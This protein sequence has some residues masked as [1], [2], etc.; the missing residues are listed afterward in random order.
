MRCPE[1]D[2]ENTDDSKF[3]MTC[4]TSL[5]DVVA[6][7]VAEPAV[8][9]GT[10]AVAESG[11]S[12][13]A[14]VSSPAPSD[15]VPEANPWLPSEATGDPAV[16]EPA[17]P[18]PAPPVDEAPA[19]PAPP[20]DEAPAPPAPLG[21]PLP[22]P[23][24]D[25][26]GALPPPPG[27]QAWTPPPP[28]SGLPTSLVPPAG[29]TPPWQADPPPPG[30]LDPIEIPVPPAAPP[31]PITMVVGPADPHGLAGQL[32]RIGDQTRAHAEGPLHLAASLLRLPEEVDVV[33]PGL[34]DGVV[35]ILVVTNE[36]ALLVNTRRWTPVV[37]DLP[38]APGLKVDGWQDEHTAVLTLTGDQ[39]ARIE[40]IVDKPL[41]FEAAR[42]IR[43]RVAAAPAAR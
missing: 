11:H 15:V 41:A 31:A 38:I 32:A 13:P 2:T 40:A 5:R 10:A 3:C 21:A 1:C 27:A 30:S 20:V 43:E 17:E 9:G 8:D 16:V 34:I 26:S 14:E 6:A 18:A 36:R 42:I 33:V 24:P 12:E 39:V 4:G 25:G 22:P 19:P 37:V 29:S 23:P 7:S 28:Q 35:G